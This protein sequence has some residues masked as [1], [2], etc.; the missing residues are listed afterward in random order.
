[1]TSTSTS[2]PTRARASPSGN[3]IDQLPVQDQAA[4]GPLASRAFDALLARDQAA[5]RRLAWV[6]ALCLAVAVAAVLLG[7]LLAERL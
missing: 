5:E 3:V 6:E 2:T 4:Q 7:R 1:M